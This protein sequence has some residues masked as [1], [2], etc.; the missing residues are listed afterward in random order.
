MRTIKEVFEYCCAVHNSNQAKS[1]S[2]ISRTAIVSVWDHGDYGQGMGVSGAMIH[3]RPAAMVCFQGTRGTNRDWA[4]NFN[5]IPDKH[6]VNK[7]FAEEF[8][9]YREELSR[10]ISKVDPSVDIY[11]TGHSQGGPT[12]IQASEYVYD[13]FCRPSSC[14]TFGCPKGFNKDARNRID[15]KSINL[16]NVINPM[17]IVTKVDPK[18][19]RPGKEFQLRND[20]WHR[21]I[22]ILFWGIEHTL[23]QYRRGIERTEKVLG[24][25]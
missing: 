20:L 10:W 14:I 16:T 5:I 19:E 13:E 4:R 9:Q 15:M 2:E 17:D 23:D 3:D 12:A 1:V 25:D 22:P 7:G 8:A 18:A 6:G 21:I 24:K 11:T